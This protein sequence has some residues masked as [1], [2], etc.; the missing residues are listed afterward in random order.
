M[1][2]YVKVLTSEG[3][4]P[5]TN[6]T[7]STYAYSNMGG[8]LYYVFSPANAAFFVNAPG[9]KSLLVNCNGYWYMYVW[10]VKYTHSN[11]NSG[12]W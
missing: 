12:G 6:A 1:S 4:L 7:F 2:L 3:G 11:H 5:I 8:G 9:R 10:L